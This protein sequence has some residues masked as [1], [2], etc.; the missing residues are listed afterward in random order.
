MRITTKGQVTIPVHIRERLG[1]LPNTE[2]EFVMDGDAVRLQKAQA[3]S[4]R[5]RRIV[6]HMRGRATSGMTTDEIMAL[7]RGEP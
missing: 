1:L 5:G 4:R 2:V 6:E 7:T 3:G